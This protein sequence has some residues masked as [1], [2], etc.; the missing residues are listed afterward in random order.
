MTRQIGAFNFFS[1]FP[2][3]PHVGGPVETSKEDGRLGK[4]EEYG[5]QAKD[6]EHLGDGTIDSTASCG[7]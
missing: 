3:G 7:F 1:R 2:T 6:P 4:G 5:F